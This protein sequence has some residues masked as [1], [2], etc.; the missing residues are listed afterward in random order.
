MSLADQK[1]RMALMFLINGVCLLL[2]AV[3]VFVA[4]RYKVDALWFVFV[5]LLITGFGAQIWFM[6]GFM[7][8]GRVE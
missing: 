6:L 7:R 5:G 2:A 4:I 1:K 3:S 8:A